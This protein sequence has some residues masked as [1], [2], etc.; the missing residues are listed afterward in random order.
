MGSLT[1]REAV[2]N[3]AGGIRDGKLMKMF[4][5]GGPLFGPIGEEGFDSP[6]DFDSIARPQAASALAA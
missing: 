4:Q 2:E 6:I 1:I 5:A 3:V